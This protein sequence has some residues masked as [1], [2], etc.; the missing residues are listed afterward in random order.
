MQLATKGAEDL[1]F[2]SYEFTLKILL[3]S[4][5]LDFIVAY[6]KLPIKYFKCLPG[7]N[8][9]NNMSKSM[10]GGEIDL[11]LGKQN[12]WQSGLSKITQTREK[13]QSLKTL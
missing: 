8:Y 10:V 3:W 2:V 9:H 4:E 7:N 13:L 12:D 6:C 1:L 5:W 11:T